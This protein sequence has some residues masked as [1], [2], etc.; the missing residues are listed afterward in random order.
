M[1]DHI[2]VARGIIQVLSSRL[3]ARIEDIGDLRARLHRVEQQHDVG[4]VRSVG[5]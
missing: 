3:R 1:A 5:L 2:E 4:L